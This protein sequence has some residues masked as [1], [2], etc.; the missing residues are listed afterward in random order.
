MLSVRPVHFGRRWRVE[1]KHFSHTMAKVT[2]PLMSL[3]ASGSVGKTLVFSKWGG[4]PY[5]RQLVTPMNPKS[6]DQN[7]VR[8]VLG[9]IAKACRAVLTSAKDVATGHP[10]SQFFQDAVAAA[11]SGQSWISYLQK[12]L[13][14]EFAGLVSAY[15]AATAEH[16]IYESHG[17]SIGLADFVDKAGVTHTAGEQL[18]LLASFAV[19][20]LG[21]TGFVAGAIGATTGELTTFDTYVNTTA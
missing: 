3:S 4:R 12:V 10:G 2:G 14:A 19:S 15:S 6:T 13:N 7:S 8:S 20:Y 21:Y 18:F 1:P 5:V 9:T 11:P 17:E 16:S